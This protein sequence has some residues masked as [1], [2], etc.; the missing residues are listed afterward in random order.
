MGPTKE[1][2]ANAIIAEM[3]AQQLEEE[4]LHPGQSSEGSEPGSKPISDKLTLQVCSSHIFQ[5]PSFQQIGSMQPNFVLA[6]EVKY[7]EYD[8]LARAKFGSMTCTHL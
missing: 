7:S 2:V 5:S 1:E 3:K 4:G 8:D 6:S